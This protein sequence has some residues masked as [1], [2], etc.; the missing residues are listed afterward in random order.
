[1]SLKSVV[2]SAVLAVSAL[3]SGAQAATVTFE[4]ASGGDLVFGGGSEAGFDYTVQTG[5]LFVNGYGNPATN[6]E[7]NIELGG[8]VV[9]FVASDAGLFAFQSLDYAAWKSSG[10]GSQVL[11]VR[12][13]LDG[14][15]LAADTFQLDNTS[16]FDPA[17]SN[18]TLFAA[19]NL[20]GLSIDQLSVELAAGNDQ[21]FNYLQTID[22]V[23]FASAVPEPATWAMMIAGFG[24]AGA[25]LRRRRQTAFA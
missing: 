15:E 8:G 4:G 11:T 17:Y 6:L 2:F 9:D 23:T 21:G 5:A 7:G 25:M 3:A 12:G 22:N 24:L 13:W 18:W 19:V 10:T 1:M 14:A 20:A 16:V